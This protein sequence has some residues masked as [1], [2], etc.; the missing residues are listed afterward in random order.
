M[1]CKANDCNCSWIRDLLRDTHTILAVSIGFRRR[2]LLL[3]WSR[4]LISGRNVGHAGDIAM[5]EYSKG[6]IGAAFQFL[7]NHA[8]RRANSSTGWRYGGRRGT[9]RRAREA[10]RF[11]PQPI[12]LKG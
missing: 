5:M 3:A 8:T 12:C 7:I 4:W 6:R 10:I 1:G 11:Q 9:S 2:S